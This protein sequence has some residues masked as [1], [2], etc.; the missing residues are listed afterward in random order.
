MQRN[1]RTGVMSMIARVCAGLAFLPVFAL[2]AAQPVQTSAQ[3]TT[4]TVPAQARSAGYTTHTFRSRF[5]P[6]SVDWND[7][8]NAKFQ[9]F[10]GRFFGY[11]PLER[12]ALS[13]PDSGEQGITLGDSGRANYGVA[14]AAPASS[15]PGWI[16]TAF[17]GGA[18]M[19]AELKFDP[20]ASRSAAQRGWPAFWSMAIEHLAGLAGE[21][22]PGQPPGYRRFIEVDI[23]EYDLQRFGLPGDLYGSALHDWYG[24]FQHTCPSGYCARST[25]NLDVRMRTPPGTDFSRYHRYGFLWIPAN[26]GQPGK[27]QFFF[28]GKPV[29]KPMTWVRAG[30]GSP[31]TE[32]KTAGFSVLDKDHLVLILGSGSAQPMTVRSVDVWQATSAANLVC[33]STHEAGCSSK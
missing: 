28:D 11:P 9:W 14:T 22:W 25:A 4:D 29:G 26:A 13:K 18:Y 2:A 23:F 7:E 3:T 30:D 19:E 27:A 10:R 21:Q 5:D 17:G 24:V 20:A 6:V 1:K 15:G 33:G 12:S 16:G 8:R 32:M 31:E